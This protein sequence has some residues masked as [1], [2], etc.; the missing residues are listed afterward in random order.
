MGNERR[1]SSQLAVDRDGCVVVDRPLEAERF[2]KLP[3]IFAGVVIGREPRHFSR[4]R[5]REFMRRC[6]MKECFLFTQ[7]SARPYGAIRE[8]PKGMIPRAL[9][10]SSSA[11]DLDP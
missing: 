7:P 11:H 4:S 1:D 6:A 10:V 5:S 2:Q 3:A 9:P 8:F